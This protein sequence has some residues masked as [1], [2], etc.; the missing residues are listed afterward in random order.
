MKKS[1]RQLVLN[2]KGPSSIYCNC[3]SPCSKLE[4]D[5]V[6]PRWYLKKVIKT[7]LKSAIT[8]PHNLYRCC[9]IMNRNKGALM[10]DIKFKSQEISGLMSRSYLYMNWR[11]NMYL[12]PSSLFYLKTIS[13]NNQPFPF[14]VERSKKIF[15]KTGVFNPFI[16]KQ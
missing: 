11:Y 13:K 1:I 6:V 10:L 8:D 5:H 9:N 4:I 16:N 15:L 7:E 3:N 2:L 12:D 14:E